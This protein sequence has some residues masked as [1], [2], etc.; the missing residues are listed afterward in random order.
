MMFIGFAVS[1]GQPSSLCDDADVVTVIGSSED[2]ANRVN[3]REVHWGVS[4]KY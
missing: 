1:P 4:Y 2:A 3:Q